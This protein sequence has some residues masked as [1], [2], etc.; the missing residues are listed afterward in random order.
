[1]WRQGGEGREGVVQGT[2]TLVSP[3]GLFTGG[4]VLHIDQEYSGLPQFWRAIPMRS[5][6]ARA[7]SAH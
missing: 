7:G 1:V 5:V 2:L 6:V 3:P 4:Q